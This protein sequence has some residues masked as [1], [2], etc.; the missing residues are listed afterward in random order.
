MN[1]NGFFSSSPSVNSSRVLYTPSFFARE[2]L[3]HLQEVGSLTAVSPHTSKREKLQSYLCF[4]VEDGEGELTY[5]GDRYLLK[6]GDV[7]F[8]DC[9]RAYSHSTNQKLWSLRWCHFNGVAMPSVYEKYKAR[10][11]RPFFQPTDA[12]KYIYLLTTLF[13]LAS[14]SD[15]IRDMRIN[16]KLNSLLTLLMEQSWNPDSATGTRKRS[17]LFKVKEY[18][19]NNYTNKITLDELASIFYIDKFYL[20]KTFKA[21]Y[22]TTISNYLITKRVTRAKQL[23]R[24]S[25][26]TIEEVGMDVGVDNACY[27]SRMF[28][29]AEGITPGEYRKQW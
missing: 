26:L 1:E 29:R 14:S 6:T 3:L 7:V 20:A 5:E 24:F 18:L 10:G 13:D 17:E 19:D 2:S 28:R 16:E 27:F 15:Y 25:D 8:I 11:G 22:G 23:L 9:R 4:V 21:V 12:N